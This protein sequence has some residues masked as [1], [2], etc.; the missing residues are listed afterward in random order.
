VIPSPAAQDGASHPSQKL[1]ERKNAAI[2]RHYLE[3]S[4]SLV[5]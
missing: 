3:I 2:R 5:L 1:S 4:R